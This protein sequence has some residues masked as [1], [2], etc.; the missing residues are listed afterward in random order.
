MGTPAEAMPGGAP[1]AAPAAGG[2]P[3][4]NGAND[5]KVTPDPVSPDVQDFLN[6]GD[7][8]AGGSP[9]AVAPAAPAAAPAKP[10]APAAAPVAP[11]AVTPPKVEPSAPAAPAPAAAAAIPAVTPPVAPPAAALAPAA[12]PV[13]P[14][15]WRQTAI[16]ELETMYAL[17]PEVGEQLTADPSQIPKVMAQLAAKLHLS[18][19]EATVNG[20]AHTLPRHIGSYLAQERANTEAK[21]AFFKR[22]PQLDE[23]T[24][25]QAALAAAQ[26]FRAANPKA[27]REQAIDFVGAQLLVQL[28]IAPGQAPVVTPPAGPVV[29]MVSPDRPASAGP[30]PSAAAAPQ[31]VDADLLDILT[32]DDEK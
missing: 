27:T 28:G 7:D 8:D 2:G 12:A 13:D 21:S 30:A 15:A 1:P 32:D 18:V 10:V 26:L 17:P 6:D 4:D 31:G 20:M 29:P 25:G 5:T 14:N 9:A 16:K 3:A 24:H 11:A 19:L 22:W 23:K